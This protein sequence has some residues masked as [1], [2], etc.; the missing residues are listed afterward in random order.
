MFLWGVE[1]IFFEGFKKTDFLY[2]KI[3][4][5][6]Q[7]L[8]THKSINLYVLHFISCY[9]LIYSHESKITFNACALCYLLK[10]KG[11]NF[12]WLCIIHERALQ[13]VTF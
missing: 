3:S 10:C 12:L 5:D 6:Q 1:K 4:I 11:N 13:F 9:K 7:K 2:T 8:I